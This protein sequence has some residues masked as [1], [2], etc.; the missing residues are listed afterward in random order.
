MSLLSGL[1]VGRP[2]NILLVGCVLL[3]V[4][5]AGR[6]GVL[7]AGRGARPMLIAAVGWLLYAGWEWLVQ[8]RTP[9]ANIRV[10]LM[11]IWPVLVVLS[12][13]GLY[14]LWR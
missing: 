5:L 14:R 8:V 3:G 1:F 13:W 4:G 6:A 7:G 9:D 12:L 2:L 10:D 11:L